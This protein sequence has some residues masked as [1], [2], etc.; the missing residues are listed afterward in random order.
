MEQNE[1]LRHAIRSLEAL[2][3]PYMIGGSLASSAYGEPRLTNDIDIVADLTD[4]QVQRLLVKFPPDEFYMDED[5]IREAIARQGQFNIIHPTSGYKVDIFICGQDAYGRSQLSRRRR[6][7]AS[8]GEHAF[9]ASPED[10]IIKK[11]EYFKIGQSERQFR[12]IVGMLRVQGEQVDRSY[13]R[14]WAARM[15]LTEVW[16]VVL[17]RAEE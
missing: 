10:V 14:Q 13:I 8:N 5:K 2:G 17:R 9:F 3:I 6:L 1:L 15:D 12:D 7:E 4:E 16:E 11:M